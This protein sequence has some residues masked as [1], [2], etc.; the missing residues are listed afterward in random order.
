MKR[1][2]LLCLIWALGAC[3][4]EKKTDEEP[5][6]AELDSYVL[7]AVPADI[8]QRTFIDFE[9][10]VQ[11]IG[12]SLEPKGVVK[13]GD[14]I[15]LTLYWQ[16]VSK[17]GRGWKLFTHLLDP[18][19][20]V[21]KDGNVDKAGPLRTSDEQALPPSRW[22]PGKI[23]VDQQ[24]FQIPADVQHGTVTIAVGIWRDA[25]RLDVISGA[26]DAQRRAL[27]VTIPTGVA[28]PKPVVRP[29]ARPEAK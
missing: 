10:K 20:K 18:N 24:E 26:H 23:Y 9:G 12:Y 2:L 22:Q 5:P 8:D 15:K 17:L 4:A 3:A 27:I 14:K 28:P 13:P 19:G 7:D 16:S 11:I 21:L 6:P 25:Y 1:S 29:Q